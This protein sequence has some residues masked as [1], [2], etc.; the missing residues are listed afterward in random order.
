MNRP[1][2]PGPALLGISSFFF[3]LMATCIGALHGAVPVSQV[4]A[5]R[6]AVGAMAMALYFA[7]R[8]KP[9]ELERWPLLVARALLGSGG[10]Y[11]YFVAI[12]QIG[13]GPATM[14]N[15]LSPVFAAFFAPYFLNERSSPRLLV[16]LAVATGGA[17]LVALGSGTGGK[18]LTLA[19]VGSGVLS[20]ILSGAA[21]TTVRGLRQSTSAFTVYF[22]FCG[23]GLLFAAPLAATEWVVLDTRAWLLV[24]AMSVVSLVGQLVYTYAMGFT[25]TVK[26]G[27]ANQLTPVFS[28][29]F[30]VLFLGDRPAT[31]TLVGTGLC[32]AGV[33]MSLTRRVVGSPAVEPG[34]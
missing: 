26:A 34:S 9:P 29:V 21:T 7:A 28:F 15:F 25:E 24:V 1:P 22:A 5:L 2:L 30:A 32:I 20:G 23:F 8:R 6:F 14:L 18:S 31:L 12:G 19:G 3:A 17:V 16:G 4:V 33:L 11:F 10:V 13:P 27:V